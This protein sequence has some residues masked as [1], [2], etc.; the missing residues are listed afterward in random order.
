MQKFYKPSPKQIEDWEY[1]YN[2]KEEFP[3]SI[4]SLI[5]E[6]D[7][8]NINA[9]RNS[10]NILISRN[11]SLRTCFPMI[12]EKIVQKVENVS[13]KFSL[14]Y[15]EEGFTT[16]PESFLRSSIFEMKDLKNGPLIKGFLY[17][18]K[19]S[20]FVIYILIHHI[21]SDFW[22]IRII[23]KQLTEIYNKITNN[24]AFEILEPKMQLGEYIEFNKDNYTVIHDKIIETWRTRLQGRRWQIDYDV[25]YKKIEFFSKKKFDSSTFNWREIDIDHLVSKPF[26][27]TYS[28][29]LTKD[30]YSKLDLFKRESKNNTN[31]IILTCLTL[32]GYLLTDNSEILIQTHYSNR[33]EELTED[34]IGN[35]IGKTLLLNTIEKDEKIDDLINKCAVNFYRS[36][37]DVFFSSKS[38]DSLNLTIRNFLFYNFISKEISENKDAE[39]LPPTHTA[40][41][42][43]ESP[44]VCHVVE[45]NNTILFSW[46]YHSG[47]FDRIAIENIVENFEIIL[48]NVITQKN[49]TIKEILLIGT[50][51]IQD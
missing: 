35:F 50:H 48:F 29:F 6:I 43:V 34:I 2:L 27:G 15:L 3:P 45:Y 21:I 36:L 19:T 13:E 22:S 39:I 1:N 42:C 24:F 12:D 33:S 25:F 30:L 38:L 11:E 14:I 17:R 40:N 7:D 46:S 26:G 8:I 37:S 49:K 51:S 31:S 41:T 4:M 5:V 10:Y 20:Q 23:K 47:F 9:F 28:H 44:L 18:K 32:L 16:E